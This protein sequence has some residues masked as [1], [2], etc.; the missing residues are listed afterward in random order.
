MDVW[1]GN[2][3]SRDGDKETPHWTDARRGLFLWDTG[4]ERTGAGFA[5]LCLGIFFYS[6]RTR[7]IFF[8]VFCFYLFIYLFKINKF[9]FTIIIIIIIV[10]FIYKLRRAPT[11]P[12]ARHTNAKAVEIRVMR[13]A[14]KEGRKG[15]KEREGGRDVCMSS[16]NVRKTYYYFYK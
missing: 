2:A 13:R 5:V 14:G 15:R 1:E 11:H 12:H 10:Y 16:A 4:C 8:F 7:E 6:R 9:R 3:N